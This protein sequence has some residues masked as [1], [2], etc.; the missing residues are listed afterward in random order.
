MV[1]LH[2]TNDPMARKGSENLTIASQV[3]HFAKEIVEVHLLQEKE[4]SNP[5]S[6]QTEPRYAFKGHNLL[7][8]LL[9]CSIGRNIF[10]SLRQ[11]FT[12]LTTIVESS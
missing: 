3:Q 7:I 10:I 12:V 1:S 6:K 9:V 11:V 2:E 5:S 8:R 4:Q